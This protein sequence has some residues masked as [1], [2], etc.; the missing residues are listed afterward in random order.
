MTYQ[1]DKEE[2]EQGEGLHDILAGDI[3]ELLLERLVVVVRLCDVV[4]LFHLLG[5]VIGGASQSAE[6][7]F[8][9]RHS[10]VTDAPDWRFRQEIGQ[11][12]KGEGGSSQNYKEII[13]V[14]KCLLIVTN[15]DL[16]GA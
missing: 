6:S 2:D 4:D 11:A 13:R 7:S 16:H 5:D 3:L 14:N 9:L 1:N 15:S 12:N 8:G 10:P